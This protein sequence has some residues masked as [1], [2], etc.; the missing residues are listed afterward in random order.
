MH[1]KQSDLKKQPGALGLRLTVKHTF[2]ILFLTTHLVKTLQA[3]K[4]S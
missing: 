2:S 3:S 1:F 4:P